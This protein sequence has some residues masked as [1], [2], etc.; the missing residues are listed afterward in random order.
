MKT[1][2]QCLK[3]GSLDRTVFSVG[4]LVGRALFGSASGRR[5]VRPKQPKPQKKS[6]EIETEIQDKLKQRKI[7]REVK[8]REKDEK[9]LEKFSISPKLHD[10][11]KNKYGPGGTHEKQGKMFRDRIGLKPGE[12]VSTA[13]DRYRY[14][15]KNAHLKKA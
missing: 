11:Y 2:K 4:R 13:L 14:E 8:R 3:E 12:K 6:H 1:F 10:Y 5:Q 9:S 15:R 7:D